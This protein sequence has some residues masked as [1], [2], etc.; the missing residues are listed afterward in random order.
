MSER[1]LRLTGGLESLL[2]PKS[3]AVVGASSDPARIGGRPI[4]Y[5]KRAG[6]EG[7]LY[8][9]NPGREEVQ[10]VKAYPD[11]D[12]IPGEVE[13]VL[14]AVSAAK[15]PEALEAAARKG[16]KA[17]LMFTAGFAEMGEE[18][19]AA[20]DR[21]VEIARANGIRLMGPNCLGL[22]N[23]ATGHCPTFTSG[24]EAGMPRPGRVGLV[25]QSGAY[26]THLL[27][28]AKDRRIGVRVWAS[29]GNEADVTAP[30]VLEHLVESDEI[31]AI[32]VYMEGLNDRDALFRA[33]EKARA[34]KK[35]VVVMK[36]GSSEVG[37]AAAASHTASL[38]G[39]DPSFDAA[40]RKFGA[41]RAKT[42]ED[43]L[44]VLYAASLAPM[45]KGRD[46]GILT[47]SGGAGVLMADAAEAEGLKLPALAQEKQAALLEGNPL[48][49][50]RNPVDITA[51]VLNDMSLVTK[52]VRIVR[53]A[54]FDMIAA[55]FTSWTASPVVGPRLRAA[56]QEG[57]EG[58]PDMPFVMVCQGDDEMAAAYEAEGMLVFEDPSRAVRALARLAEL[59]EG[60]RAAE[61]G[62]E[63]VPEVDVRLPAGLVGEAEAKRVMAAAGIPVPEERVVATPEAAAE[64]AAEIG[65][66]AVLK[67]VSPDIAHKTEVGGVALGLADADAVRAAAA[68]MLDSVA[69]K[70]PGAKIDGLLVGRMAGEG[71]ELIVG[72]R[73]DP[74]M[75][76]IVM[77][78]LG[79]VFTEVLRD[80]DVSLA[81]VTRS[82]ARAALERLRGAALLK[83]ARGR[84]AVDMDAAADAISRLSALAAANAE[85]FESIEINPLL[86]RADG[87]VALDALIVPREGAARP[88][89]HADF[90]VGTGIGEAEIRLDED[91]L[92]LWEK[93]YG[94]RPEAGRPVPRGLLVAAM[95]EGYTRAIQP[96][97]PGN[98]H[99]GQTLRFTGAPPAPGA[100]LTLRLSCL[101]KE[102]R[103]GRNWIGFGV[104]L[105]EGERL[106]M[107]GE[108]TSIW[109][110]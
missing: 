80:V 49:S 18:G 93:T 91:R 106:A 83:G 67:I 94:R 110:A 14:L 3:V 35:P 2:A 99:A 45:P 102:V 61:Q 109:A 24:L 5:Y 66:P 16:A 56:L 87:V 40:M 75:G 4:A 73:R 52:G 77:V 20:Q 107:T 41:L 81:P 30:E 6:Y 97:P 50:A 28:M 71:V 82:E 84:P 47:V 98:V 7:A 44:D 53:D 70:A 57:L 96:R 65:F 21:L 101:W 104:E 79:G 59:A 42:T 23:A 100:A 51:N 29:T 74:V 85:G 19:R 9:V 78:G 95:M 12:S 90:E 103:K 11:L 8:P 38:A 31:D 13:F 108:I 69:E 10:G 39:S 32:G 92:A 68:R 34:A 62:A 27:N 72:A 86:A 48:A 58:R 17:A 43:L 54:G 1:D 36:V 33:L 25:T 105:R 63:A 46:L 76:P 88:W 60:F 22:F 64:A 89:R 55:F 37:A 26:G 15:A